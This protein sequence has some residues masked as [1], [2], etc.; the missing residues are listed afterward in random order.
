M[1]L[2]FRVANHL[3]LRDEQELLFIAENRDSN[4][5]MSATFALKSVPS[6][7]NLSGLPV[8]IIYGANASGKSNIVAALR[9]MREAVLESQRGWRPGAA[10]HRQAFALDNDFVD[11][12]TM[13]EIDLTIEGIRHQYGFEIYD[14]AFVSE[15]LFYYPQGKP[16]RIFERKGKDFTF[17]KSLKG[18]KEAIARLTRENSL[19]LSAGAQNDHPLLSSVFDAFN[20]ISGFE[21]LDVHTPQVISFFEQRGEIDDRIITFLQRLDTGIVSYRWDEAPYNFDEDFREK[22]LDIFKDEYRDRVNF[23]NKQL[24]LLHEAKDSQQV[25][26]DL[27]RES[28]GTRRLLM[29]L[30]HI[31]EA[32]DEGTPFVLDEIDSSLHT[33]AVEQIIGLF[34]SGKTNP[35]GAQLIATTHDTNL[36]RSGYLR[37]D[38]IWFTEKDNFGATILYPLT[39][40]MPRRSA[41]LERGYL[42]GR[43]GAV[44][45]SGPVLDQIASAGVRKN[46]KGKDKS[47]PKKAT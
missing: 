16:A 13:F 29:T 40:Y 31:F 25:A 9:F 42:M 33:L 47:S 18:E 14:D 24:H 12:P 19:F 22:I 30:C 32:L 17:G 43:Y 34:A 8:A 2:R 44:P 1:I 38:E 10:V 37:R 45:F 36:L 28:R 21:L 26:M 39:D 20:K 7:K 6:L 3:S 5:N 15:W 46:A 4:E 23:Q 27:A 35:Y 41:N 11:K